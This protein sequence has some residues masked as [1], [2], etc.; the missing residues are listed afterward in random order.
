M[1][2]GLLSVIL[3]WLSASAAAA[4]YSDQA[5]SLTTSSGT[6][7]GSLVL[8]A[9]KE[10]SAVALIIPGSGPVDRNG[11]VGAANATTNSLKYLAE[12]LAQAGFASVRYDKRGIAASGAAITN[13]AEL[14][15]ETYINDAAAW[16]EQL[17]RDPRFSSVAVIGHSEGSLIGMLAARQANADAFVS[18][19]GLAT[20]A[21]ETVRAQLKNRLTGALAERSQEI[22]KGL[23]QGRTTK[24]VPKEL[25]ALY[26]ESVQPYLISWFRYIPSVELAKLTVPVL[27]LHGGT[28]IQINVTEAEALKRAKP[29]AEL[30]IVP[31]M[32]HV[33]KA[34][35]A[36]MSKQMASYNDPALPLAAEL[37]APLIGFLKKSLR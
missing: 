26:R 28:D 29:D 4:A 13:E 6:L 30:V 19:A 11:N 37:N 14:R 9:G 1:R 34:V 16:I 35:P 3:I 2:R 8:P 21:A 23:E 5:I 25:A 20:G 31:G 27:L 15:F 32:N 7:A 10:K 18:I 33:L 12:S 36:D 22:L 17:K 24:D